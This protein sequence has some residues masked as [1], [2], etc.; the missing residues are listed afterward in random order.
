MKKEP[1][2]HKPT[3]KEILLDD[4]NGFIPLPRQL[5]TILGFNATGLLVELYDRY[6][7]YSSQQSLNTY[8]EFFYTVNDIEINTGLSRREQ[9]T[10]I[11]ILKEYNF[12]ER[13]ISRDMPP[14]RYFLMNS[15]ITHLLKNIY[16]KAEEKK[17][18]II[19]RNKTEIERM[20]GT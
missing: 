1:I 13:I 9:T 10:S 8:G 11:K 4:S 7:Y 17:S 18:N 15:N 19:E 5:I 20:L 2:E 6:D 12:I 3:L 16:K 14:K